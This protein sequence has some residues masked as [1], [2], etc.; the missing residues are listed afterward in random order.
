MGIDLKILASHFREH[1]GEFLATATIRLD[2]DSRLLSLLSSIAEPI[3][4]G[5]KVG[6]YEDDGIHFDENDR[7]GDR[8]TFTTPERVRSLRPV[9][10]LSDW[11]RAALAF[12]LSLP[13]G[14]RLVLYWC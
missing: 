11:N 12:V 6:H 2:R 5:L 13:P 7:R 9:E 10:D 4:D 14:A 1:R 3:P 8:L